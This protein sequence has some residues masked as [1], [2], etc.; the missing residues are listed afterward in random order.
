MKRRLKYIP[1]WSALMLAGA[2]A[3]TSCDK[4]EREQLRAEAAELEQKLQERDSAFNSIMNVM[5]EVENE[6]N[7]IKEEENIIAN[8]S[9]ND[10]SSS[11]DSQMI[12]DLGRINTLIDNA[13]A[14][15]QQLS[16]KLDASNFE[17]KAFKNKVSDLK[18][19]FVERAK[20]IAQLK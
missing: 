20:S 10:F 19:D 4:A 8:H 2:L 12:T 15:I 13:N 3:M 5:A 14:K 9:K 18:N 7:R 16:E 17:L 6:I 11:D 1:K